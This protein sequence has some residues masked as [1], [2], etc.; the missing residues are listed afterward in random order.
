MIVLECR[1]WRQVVGPYKVAAGHSYYPLLEKAPNVGL[2]APLRVLLG[3]QLRLV[4]PVVPLQSEDMGSERVRE[5]REEAVDESKR[6]S[7]P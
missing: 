7:F 5:V 1:Y 4:R 3:H 2:L 6:V